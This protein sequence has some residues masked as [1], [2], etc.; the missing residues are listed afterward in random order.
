MKTTKLLL[1]LLLFTVSSA[2]AQYVGLKSLTEEP[3][4]KCIP[5]TTSVAVRVGTE[6]IFVCYDDIEI[7]GQNSNSKISIELDT[8]G[9]RICEPYF[10]NKDSVISSIAEDINLM[11]ENNEIVIEQISHPNIYLDSVCT[12]DV[13]PQI[14]KNLKKGD[15]FH[16]LKVVKRV[17]NYYW[18]ETPSGFFVHIKFD[19]KKSAKILG[20]WNTPKGKPLLDPRKRAK[21]IKEVEEIL[22]IKD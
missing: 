14:F 1:L 22:N 13:N 4:K 11:L 10:A 12:V 16:Y 18:V 2:Q 19:N 5:D 7:I 6:W 8:S 15:L 20:I 21:V 9:I 17:F 3:M